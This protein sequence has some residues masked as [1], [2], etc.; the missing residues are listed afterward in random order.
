MATQEVPH[1]ARRLR[2]LRSSS[3]GLEGLCARWVLP[4]IP[5]VLFILLQVEFG[6]AEEPERYLG[7]TKDAAITDG[8]RTPITS[9]SNFADDACTAFVVGYTEIILCS[10]SFI[11]HVGALSR[12]MQRGAQAYLVLRYP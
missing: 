11:S 1:D 8:H 6:S 5:V 3:R 10:Q 9:Y 2:T 7:Q 12:S 4:V